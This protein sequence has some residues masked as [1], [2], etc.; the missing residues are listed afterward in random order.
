MDIRP[1]RSDID[2]AEALREKERLRG[3]E[4]GTADGDKPDVLAA[5]VDSAAWK[6]AIQLLVTP[7]EVTAA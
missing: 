4:P 7:H 1:T 2:H 6:I 3:A 5:L